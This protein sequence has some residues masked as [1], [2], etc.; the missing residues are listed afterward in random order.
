MTNLRPVSARRHP[1]QVLLAA[2][3]LISGLSILLGGP[4]P[5]SIAAV[6]PGLLVV[7]WA[8]TLVVGS[9]LVVAAAV[10]GSEELALYLEL[11]ADL[12]LAIMCAVYAV[13][14]ITVAGAAGMFPAS[15][16]L[17]MGLAFLIRGHQVH[18][19][20]RLLRTGLSEGP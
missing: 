8:G 7:V 17:G 4:R 14:V 6:L 9:A 13:A 3:L 18:Q 12:P 2:L 11:V 1:H 15:I 16:V 10:V 5:G 19:T 20:L